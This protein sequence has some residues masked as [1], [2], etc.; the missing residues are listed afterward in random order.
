ML[1]VSLLHTNNVARL[2]GRVW[3]KGKVHPLQIQMVGPRLNT[4]FEAAPKEV[5]RP[6]IAGVD[7][8]VL[9]FDNGAKDEI[10]LVL[11]KLC[12]S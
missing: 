9:A 7:L 1:G 3:L 10:E 5:W 11:K 12:I 2:K 8:V 6:P 4:W